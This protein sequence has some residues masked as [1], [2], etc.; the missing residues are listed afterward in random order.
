MR[1]LRALPREFD[2][3]VVNDGSTDRTGV[4]ADELAHADRQR[5]YTVH[6]KHNCGIGV[7]VQTGYLF[8]SQNGGYKYVIQFD[9]DGQH[10][11]ESIGQLVV[12]C[13]RDELDLC[14]GSRFM[15]GAGGGFQSTPLRR[16][17]IRFFGLLLGCLTRVRVS[18]PTSGFRCAGPRAWRWFAESYPDDYPEPE[19][20]FWCLHNSMKVGEVPVEMQAR[21]GGE[22]SIDSL[23]SVYYMTK[24]TL[25]ILCAWMRRREPAIE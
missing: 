13:E 25:A 12:A 6:L 4:I 3:L 14:V 23:H 2:I 21:R 7:A 18:D 19:S 22:S 1:K 9:G 10:D 5:V 17:G 20:L 15:N 8:A 16:V 24:V 11:S